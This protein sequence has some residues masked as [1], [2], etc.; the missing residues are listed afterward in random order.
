MAPEPKAEAHASAQIFRALRSVR[1][2]GMSSIG[3]RNPTLE[4]AVAII[5]QQLTR[6]SQAAQLRFMRDNQGDEFAQRVKANV[7]AAGKARKR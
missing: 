7:I 5:G 1:E 2:E 3:V 4:E 6:S